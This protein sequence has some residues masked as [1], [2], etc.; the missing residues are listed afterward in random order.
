ME[1][2]VAVRLLV[3]DDDTSVRMALGIALDDVEVLEAWRAGAVVALAL[4]NEL[5]GVVIDRRLPDGDG[6]DVVRALRAEPRTAD[7]PIVVV[8]ASDDPD[9]RPLAF[10]AGA[11]EHVV[12]PVDPA[13]LLALLRAIAE[14]APT[15]RRLRRTVHR[16]RMHAG[17]DDGG[18]V[19]LLPDVQP[20]VAAS[21]GRRRWRVRMG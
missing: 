18:Q 19:D 8:T 14:V 4:A 20:A 5:D 17:R 11:D 9:E 1:D 21:D 13:R 3:L 6:L 15:Q 7:L 2:A 10:A 12:K 16:A